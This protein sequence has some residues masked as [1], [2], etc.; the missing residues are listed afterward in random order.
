MKWLL[1][2]AVLFLSGYTSANRP[3]LSVTPWAHD[4]D[5]ATTPGVQVTVKWKLP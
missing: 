1:V 2:G 5:W 3:S 4:Q